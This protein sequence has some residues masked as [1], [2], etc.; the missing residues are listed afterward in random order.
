M[1]WSWR[2]GGP[3]LPV[4]EGGSANSEGRRPCPLAG[5][6]GGEAAGGTEGLR[7]QEKDR[8]IRRKR[9]S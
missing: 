8:Y 5:I 7:E 4:T 2:R 9:Q 3:A 6:E 1:G